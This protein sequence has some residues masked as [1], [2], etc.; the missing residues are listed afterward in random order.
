[1][2]QWRGIDEA[3]AAFGGAVPDFGIQS[4]YF[5]GGHRQRRLAVS[6]QEVVHPA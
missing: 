1:M 4:T 2:A 5:E 3:L 6:F